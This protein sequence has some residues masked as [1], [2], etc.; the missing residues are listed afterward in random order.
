MRPDF[1]RVVTEAPR[2]GSHWRN[3]KTRLRISGKLYDPDIHDDL[4]SRE[5][6]FPNPSK[7][8]SDILGPIN[9][10][11]RSRVGRLWDDVYSEIR[12]VISPNASEPIR[13]IWE[14]HFKGEVLTNCFLNDDKKIYHIGK[15][16]GLREVEGFFV[17]PETGKLEYKE[18]NS[19]R[20][21]RTVRSIG[22]GF[23]V[24]GQNEKDPDTGEW[25]SQFSFIA[26][27]DDLIRAEKRK[28]FWFLL[29]YRHLAEEER[30]VRDLLGRVINVLPPLKLI[31]E[32][33][34]SKK[35][36]RKL[37]LK[38]NRLVF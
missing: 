17:H 24:L 1:Y 28:G 10:F 23:V 20:F 11:L 34:A 25:G 31:S 12:S 35:E 9:G 32:K 30:N 21:K 16:V 18:Y 19:R 26:K 7:G 33:Q 6:I 22:N 3:L 2:H 38:N 13:H 5:K 29:F 37:G 4:P 36:L 27:V 15:F 14:V 8:F